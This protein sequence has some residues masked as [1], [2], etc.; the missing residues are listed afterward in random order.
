MSNPKVIAQS[1]PASLQLFLCLQTLDVLTTCLGFRLG[2][3]EASPF[4]QVLMGM[5]PI[6]GLLASKVIALSLGGFCIWRERLRV[7]LWINYWYTALVIWN[8]TLIVT[9]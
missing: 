6:A 4:I 2:L 5:G 7:I 3:H 9:R 1:W 8:L